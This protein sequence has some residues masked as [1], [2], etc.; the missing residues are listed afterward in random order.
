[1]ALLKEHKKEIVK[2]FKKSELD[3]GSPE[4]QVALLTFRILGLTEHFKEHKLDVHGRI[5]MR[6]LVNQ[7]K[8]LLEYL[9]RKDKT[10]FDILV[11][12]L[13]LRG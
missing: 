13:E 5:G 1:M 2:K 8:S 9:K 3:T 12:E 4:V 11:K 6:D 7:R 10:R